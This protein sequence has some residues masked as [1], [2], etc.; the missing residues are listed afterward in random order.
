MED[1][2]Q[3]VQRL[4]QHLKYEFPK[5]QDRQRLKE[6]I[7]YI[8]DHSEDDSNFGTVKLNKILYFA[9]FQAYVHLG[10]PITGVTYI[11][12]DNGPVPEDFY[13]VRAE[14]LAA[15]D[16][17]IKS[18]QRYEHVQERV[19]AL[20]M[21]QLALFTAEE[22]SLVDEVIYELRERNA[23]EVSEMSHGRAWQVARH[24]ER[25]PY[26]AALLSSEGV[27]AEDIAITQRLAKEHS[28]NIPGR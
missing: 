26:N 5:G 1:Q 7:L 2:M 18:R 15:G 22:I 9:D 21:P 24:K 25:I 20:R 10:E 12:L 4:Q 6:L 16:I 14:M 8:A 27:T 23:S 3:L 19:I 28:W 17:I 11:K 13:S